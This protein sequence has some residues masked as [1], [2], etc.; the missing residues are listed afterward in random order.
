MHKRAN[1]SATA[2]NSHKGGPVLVE[3]IPTAGVPLADA[4]N[5]RVDRLAAVDVLHGRFAEEEVHVVAHLKGAHKVW[6]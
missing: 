4:G 1:S 2:K 6:F 3:N 5:A